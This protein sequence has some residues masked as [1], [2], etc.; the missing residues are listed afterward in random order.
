MGTAS[1]CGAGEQGLAHLI[2]VFDLSDAR[3]GH[4]YDSDVQQ[5]VG[6]LLH[7]VLIARKCLVGLAPA[8]SRRIGLALFLRDYALINLVIEW[9]IAIENR[10]EGDDQ[11][12]GDRL[13]GDHGDRADQRRHRQVPKHV[14]VTMLGTDAV[15]RADRDCE[16]YHQSDGSGL[17]K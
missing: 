16:N 5:G 10:G 9:Y 17:R 1:L 14:L 7:A 3:Q 4:D 12:G 2:D 15:K 8:V 13:G 6:Q 11:E